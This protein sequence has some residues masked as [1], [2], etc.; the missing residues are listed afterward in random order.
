MNH[1]IVVA[2]LLCAG[3]N[4]AG[5]ESA[6][7]RPN[8]LLIAI[9]DLN[10]W[11]G[12]LGGH[13][14][15]KTPNID[16]LAG[17]G[18]LF[19]N[20]HCQAPICGPSRASL[21]SGRYPHSTGVY[22][23]PD[24]K[25]LSEDRELFR[26][27]LLPEYFAQHGYETLAVGKITH[28]YPHDVAFQRYGG[29]LGGSGPKP[30]DK[31]V[32]FQY[33]PDLSIPFTGTQT[34]WGPFPDVD[35]KM[36]DH[37]AADWAVEQLGRKHATPFFLAVG[38][39]RPHVPFYVPQK[40]FDQFPLKDVQIPVIPD[41]DLDDV[42][43]IGRQL[44]ELPRYP[45]LDWLRRSDNEQLKRCVQAYL[46]CTA[47]VDHQVGRV[48]DALAARSDADNTVVV[49]F[50]DHG[51][52]LGEKHRVSKHGLWEESTRVPLVV[53]RPG[54]TKG[55]ASGKPVGLIDLY[56][57]LL[58]LT[59]LP[60]RPANEG[61]SLVP[62]LE[63]PEAEWRFATST[64]YGRMNHSLRS[65]DYRFIRYE[66]GSEEL[67]DHAADPD[68]WTNLAT[69]P[70]HRAIVHEFRAALPGVDSPHHTSTRT[71]PVNAWFK[72]VFVRHRVGEDSETLP[73]LFDGTTFDNWMTL[74]GKPVTQ[75][76]EVVDGAI[77]LNREKKR[78][79]HI[80]TRHEYGDFDLSFDWKIAARGNSGLKYRVR[81]YGKKTL[82][83]EY[84]IIDDG[85]TGK[86][87]GRGST[88][89]LYALFE[90]DPEIHLNPV[91]EFNSSRIIVRGDHIE[92]W[93]N[94][95]LVVSATVGSPE[96]DERVG[97][98][99]FSSETTFGR[100]RL[101]RIMLTDHGSE[102]WY[103]NLEIRRPASSDSVTD[104]D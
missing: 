88:A 58:E 55:Q 92:H 81:R 87:L 1:R 54:E 30:G 42:P 45:Q 100:N 74:D 36:P 8:V 70:K 7:P 5:A 93:L 85:K 82:G 56:P 17:R 76:W 78:A 31:T 34:D 83:C 99:K 79:G 27:H 20:A 66:N 97:S 3:L 69:S 103:R 59:G 98:S 96:W 24:K 15:T 16:A 63:N 48:L 90:P 91:G 28:G 57:T 26:G 102:V 65:E 80:V 77:R 32:R 44:H 51:Y 49:L 14:Q 60:E 89:S 13:P 104:T 94:G 37:K 46:A 33:S 53:C 43:E 95:R 52:H 62:L 84:Q 2:V 12:C 41:D 40:W 22:Q 29:G 19:T 38:F 25:G 39:V 75:G 9:D 11:V 47:F 72:D 71:S 10:D 35:E 67:Y 86:S 73:P 61:Q 4:A 23:Q 68:E 101:G 6:D 64:T 50:S 21:L 18:T